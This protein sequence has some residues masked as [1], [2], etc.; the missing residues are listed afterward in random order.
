MMKQPASLKLALCLSVAVSVHLT[1]FAAMAPPADTVRIKG[2]A[3]RVA[4][5]SSAAFLEAIESAPDTVSTDKQAE[6]TFEESPPPEPEPETQPLPAAVKKP[7]A[8]PALLPESDRPLQPMPAPPPSTS[9]VP[10]S[11]TS[12]AKK[13]ADGMPEATAHSGDERTSA[14][15][16]PPAETAQAAN[17][18]ASA[19]S[20]PAHPAGMSPGNADASNYAGEVMQH[21]STV[22]RPRAPAPGS[23]Y[24]AF[25]ISR[26]GDIEDIAVSRSSGSTRFDREALKVVE[27]A[28]P[29]P[30]PPHGVNRTF[31]IRIEGR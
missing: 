29:F 3:T 10:Y 30:V 27:R 28:S 13:A 19:A 8:E 26:S 31:E 21:L 1:V 20:G 25:T 14:K 23:A 7:A 11:A 4:F 9:P 18:A 6:E 16:N 24:I 17:M 22:P 12:A 2:G 15:Q 5:G